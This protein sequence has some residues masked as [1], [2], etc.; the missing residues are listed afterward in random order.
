M[1]NWITLLF[2]VSKIGL[3]QS[4]SLA[5]R[6]DK[7]NWFK[8]DLNSEKKSMWKKSIVPSVLMIS[9][10]SINTLPLKQDIQDKIRKPF[11]GYTTSM[12]DYI[13]YVPI[14]LMYGADLFKIKAEHSVWN[15][16]KYLF[17]SEV[18][19]SGIVFGLKYGVGILRPDSSTYNSF[20]SGH[21]AQAFVAAQVLHNEFKNTNKVLANSG[22][23]FSTSTG[24]LRIVNN[25]HWLPDVLMGAGIAI[26]VTNLVYHFEPLKNWKPKFLKSK[27]DLSLQFSPIFSDQMVGAN[28][29]LKL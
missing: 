17:F 21:T 12:D 18:I 26:I 15:Q 22:Y 28:L 19:T 4:D 11:N 2:L 14:G 8:T 13:Q 1:K 27:S 6:Y 3:S 10:L 29:K 7:I 24:F 5:K 20:P 25:R 23:L 16:T 9:A